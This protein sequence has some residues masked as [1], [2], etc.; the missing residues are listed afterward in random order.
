MTLV[1]VHDLECEQMNVMLI[2]SH[3]KLKDHQIYVEL[4][5]DIKLSSKVKVENVIELLNRVLYD[6]K[7]KTRI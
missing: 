5:S 2:Y 7:Q 1:A 3:D 6:F 4:F